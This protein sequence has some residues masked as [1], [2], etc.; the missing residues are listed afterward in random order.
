VKRWIVVVG[1]ILVATPAH[2]QQC[3]HGTDE[4]PEEK[5]RKRSALGATR[6]VNNLQANQDGARTSTF[7]TH[8]HL[9]TSRFAHGPNGQDEF[10]RTLN[11]RPGEEILPG[12]EL[13][14]DVTKTG[15]W[16]MVRDKTDPC[17]FAYVSNQQGII[18]TSEPI[19]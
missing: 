11:F 2:A 18:Y 6:M 13:K 5:A 7:L 12:W 19:R 14:L 15:Y 10:F 4:Q 8:E 3:L 17:G 1:L 9:L 16:F